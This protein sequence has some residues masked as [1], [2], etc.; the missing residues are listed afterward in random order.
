MRKAKSKEGW[1]QRQKK[2]QYVQA[3]RKEGLRSR[4]AFKLEQINKKYKILDSGY[5]VL[6]L[7]C[8][9][10][11]WL[12]VARKYVGES[13]KIV[14]V[15][16]HDMDPIKGVDFIKGDFRDPKIVEQIQ[17]RLGIQGLDLVISD[18]APNITGIR[19]TD[20]ANFLE[21]AELVQEFS[22]ENLKP[23]GNLLFKCFEG[24]GM[25]ALRS[26]L[27]DQ[28]R[29]STHIKPAASRKESREFYVLSK[30]PLVK[31]R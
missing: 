17:E 18:M 29:K 16:L 1:L 21:L 30:N 19:E 15:D 14:G 12:Q 24:M 10:G 2:D 31:V 7:G 11:G 9:P 8:A 26:N 28:F 5:R 13:G 4:A 25:K 20:Q 6:D 27:K 22:L 3:S 23:K